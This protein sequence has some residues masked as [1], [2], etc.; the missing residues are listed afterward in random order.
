MLFASLLY[1]MVDTDATA[2]RRPLYMTMDVEHV[3][4]SHIYMTIVVKELREKN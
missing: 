2:I 1:V 4:K 3:I